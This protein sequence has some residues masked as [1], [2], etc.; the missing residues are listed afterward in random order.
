ML[1]KCISYTHPSDKLAHMNI[2]RRLN[3][4]V[5]VQL[6]EELTLMVTYLLMTF[7]SLKYLCRLKIKSCFYFS[8]NHSE[9]PATDHLHNALC[10]QTECNMCVLYYTY[11][12]CREVRLPVTNGGYELLKDYILLYDCIILFTLPLLIPEKLLSSAYCPRVHRRAWDKEQSWIC[13]K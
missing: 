10:I 4:L 6:A 8:E 11:H 7:L 3:L 2:R 9:W 1:Y 12:F 13:R 5:I